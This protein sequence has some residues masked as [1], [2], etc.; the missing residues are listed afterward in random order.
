MLLPSHCYTAKLRKQARKDCSCYQDERSVTISSLAKRTWWIWRIIKLFILQHLQLQ[1]QH[2]PYKRIALCG[3]RQHAKQ[4]TLKPR[5]SYF[6]SDNIPFRSPTQ[7]IS[8]RATLLIQDHRRCSQVLRVE[9]PAILLFVGASS[10]SD[11]C[12]LPQ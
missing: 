11:D 5:C 12:L 10:L 3:S 1:L 2:R 7:H 6:H 4:A 9:V 8:H